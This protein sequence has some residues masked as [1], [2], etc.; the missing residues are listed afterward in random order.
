VFSLGLAAFPAILL[1]G[2]DS[3]A[4]SLVGGLLI[5][6]GQAA[7]GVYLGGSWQDVVAYAA[8]LV[9]L[10]VRPQGIFGDARVARL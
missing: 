6:L 3:I 4:G 5:G 9:V 1:G 8:L 2:L 10:L 7:I